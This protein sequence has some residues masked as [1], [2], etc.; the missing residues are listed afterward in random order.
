MDAFYASVE[1]LDRPELRG[2]PVIV[3]GLGPRGVVATASYEARACGVHSAMP[4]ARARKL[5]P[6]AAFLPPRFSRYEEVAARIRRILREYTPLVEPISLDE[7]FL[8]LSGTERLHGP[9]EAVAQEIH[10][11]IP[12]EVG[13]SCSV[14]LAPNKLLAKM[15]SSSAKPGGIVIVRPEDIVGFLDPLPVDRLWG[16]GPK[17]AAEL[18]RRGVRTV[19]DLR[20][21]DAS[22]LVSWFGPRSG[23]RLWQMA[24]GLDDS[25]VSPEREA[26]SISQEETYPD[27]LYDPGEIRDRI[28][29]L[30]VKVAARLRAEGLMA[31]SVRIKVRTADFAT[32]TRQIRLP[33][34]TSHPLLV[35][36]AA[37]ALLKRLDYADRGVRL[38]GVGAGGL[39][40]E[41][42]RPLH[43]FVGEGLAEALGELGERYG[44]GTVTPGTD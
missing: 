27:D 16:V 2:R 11:R 36:E 24:R 5:C 4:M 8:D 35:A 30:A 29:R 21:V 3:G 7:A 40:P 20:E 10:A 9:A 19:R 38:L 1:Q 34:P 32:H 6:G 42:F 22:L 18:A 41:D 33:E 12:R 25:P 15:A 13:L 23:M 31:R 26:K 14:G 28:R 17:T 44:P 39:V 37:L 43:L